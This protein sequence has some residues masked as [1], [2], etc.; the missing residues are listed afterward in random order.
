M[1]LGVA[2]KKNHGASKLSQGLLDKRWC[3]A[4]KSYKSNACYTHT[5]MEN[6]DGIQ[7]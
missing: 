6:T 1:R 5:S 7:K 4:K 2:V 3:G